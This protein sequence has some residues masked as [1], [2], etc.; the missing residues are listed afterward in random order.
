METST[1]LFGNSGRE[2]TDN[3]LYNTGHIIHK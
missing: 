2:Y 1:Q 3:I